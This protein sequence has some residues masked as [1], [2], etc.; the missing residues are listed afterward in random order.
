MINCLNI[1]IFLH[2]RD[3]CTYLQV[4]CIIDVYRHFRISKSVSKKM[5]QLP[6]FIFVLDKIISHPHSA[7]WALFWKL[8][9]MPNLFWTPHIEKWS[10]K[11][12]CRMKKCQQNCP[13]RSKTCKIEHF[14]KLS[15]KSQKTL[16]RPH[17]I[18]Y[19][20]QLTPSKIKYCTKMPDNYFIS[21]N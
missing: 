5:W 7:I 17:L 6:S 21:L 19:I 1:A 4:V 8:P 14:S 18:Y 13:K 15:K 10:E 12:E 9:F 2:T 20:C 11:K 16:G 3:R